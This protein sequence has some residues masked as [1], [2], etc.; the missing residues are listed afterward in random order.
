[1]TVAVAIDDILGRITKGTGGSDDFQVERAQIQSWIVGNIDAV[2]KEY[3]D[4]QIAAAKPIDTIFLQKEACKLIADEDESC[5]DDEDE[6]SYVTVTYQPMSLLNDMGIVRVT[7]NDGYY[8]HRTR[9]ESID[10]V[11]DLP[12][13]QPTKDHLVW[14]RENKK[15]FIEGFNNTPNTKFIVWYIPTADSQTITEASDIKLPGELIQ[16]LLERVE[17]IALRELG[18]FIDQENNG[19]TSN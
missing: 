15:L 13:A 1:M 9:E 14:Y 2:A 19:E 10:I 5:V 4:L 16:P 11:R 8:V 6:R 17:Q 18:T 3:L 7:T 12:Y